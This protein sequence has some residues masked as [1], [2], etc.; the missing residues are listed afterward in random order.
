VYVHITQSIKIEGT[1][2]YK[3][4][5]ECP[6][7]SVKAILHSIKYL[8]S[9]TLDKDFID[10]WFFIEYFFFCRVSENTRQIKNHKKLQKKF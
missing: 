6:N 1:L 5:V 3:F 8:P 2:P 10:K 7:H 9:I 4:F